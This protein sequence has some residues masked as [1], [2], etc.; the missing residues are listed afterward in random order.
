MRFLIS[1]LLKIKL[2]NAFVS[3]KVTKTMITLSRRQFHPKLRLEQTEL[4]QTTNA[5]L[6][7][8]IVMTLESIV[9]NRTLVYSI[10]HCLKSDACVCLESDTSA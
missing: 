2:S 1:S 9:Q 7:I 5:S 8:D 6:I 4:E 3:A 10:G